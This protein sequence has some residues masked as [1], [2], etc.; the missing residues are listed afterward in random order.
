MQLRLPLLNVLILALTIALVW[1]RPGI[2]PLAPQDRSV[3][4]AAIG[5]PFVLTN[6]DGQT[7]REEDFR[8]KLMLVFF[9]FTHCPDVCP[10]SAASLSQV[11]KQLGDKATQVA[12]IFISVDPKRDTPAVVKSYFANFDP[13]IV[14]LTGDDEAVKQAASAYK[15]YYAAVAM[16]GGND[17]MVNH[18]SFIYLMDKK[19]KYLQHFAYDA[20]ADDITKAV[21][22]RLK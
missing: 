19:G 6:Q 5:G 7:V 9:G 13:R 17:Y 18:S 22:T 1:S 4:E 21:K 3:G 16:D 12:P 15:V 2:N 20:P 8:G 11:M 14:A 10:T